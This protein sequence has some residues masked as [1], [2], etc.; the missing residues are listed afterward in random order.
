MMTIK[1]RQQV[2]VYS[3]SDT[4]VYYRFELYGDD[5]SDLPAPTDISGCTIVQGST[6]HIISTDEDYQ[7]QSDGTWTLQRS[8]DLS[9]IIT[10]ISQMQ[11][12]ITDLDTDLTT[13]QQKLQK[14]EPALI[15]LINDGAKN[16]LNLTPASITQTSNGVT[17][18]YDPAAGSVTLSGQH[19]SSDPASIF[20]LYTGNAADQYEIPAGDYFISGVPA[21]GSTSTYRAILRGIT[22]AV[23]IGDGKS[24]TLTA[25]H[26][27]AYAILISGNV[28]F[29]SGVIWYPMVS[30]QSYHDM[31]PDF[32][33]YS[34]TNR[35]L[36][37]LIRS[38]HP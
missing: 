25:P 14:I 32:Q 38:Y 28:D 12:D 9:T 34:P 33:I 13:V 22:A 29:G 23:D 10:E 4:T 16:K 15:Q 1:D 18:V 19:I 3:D 24:F 21:G 6:M 20:N 7:M 35:E 17:M 11:S 31:T 26:Y 5:V 37:D 8:A 30:Y 36:L 27:V 2:D